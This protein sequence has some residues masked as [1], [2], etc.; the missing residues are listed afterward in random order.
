MM[1]GISRPDSLSSLDIGN[2]Y[3]QFAWAYRRYWGDH[4][5]HGFFLT[6]NEDREQSQQAMVHY[7][8][9]RAGLVAGM[10]VA[11]VG[12]GHGGT[13]SLLAKEYSCKVLGLTI[14]ETQLK[15]AREACASLDGNVRFELANA[16]E[17]AFPPGNFDVIWNME[18]SEHFFDKTGYFR[19][20]A[21]ALKPGGKLMVA[22][23][24]GSMKD[25]MIRD[26]ARVFLCPELWTACEYQAQVE[27]AGLK[28][29]L[30]EQLSSEVARTWDIAAER[31][32][33]S[34]WMLALLPAAFSQFTQG[35]EL[36]REGYRSG[37]LRYLVLVA[38]RP[39]Q[40]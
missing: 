11:D 13:A 35:I 39:C 19:K 1:T 10:S 29:T 21:H 34:R 7:C 8:A 31:V 18:S 16:E 9:A 38:D 2:H 33:K 24:S 6:G 37:Q 14:S 5:H 26:I 27:A 25:Q 22:A 3:N 4:I 32:E 40:E 15:F 30:C 20:V 12:C 28:V 23:W 36:M 17:Y